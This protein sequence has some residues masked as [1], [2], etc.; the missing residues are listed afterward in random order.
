[1]Y[2]NDVTSDDEENFDHDYIIIEGPVEGED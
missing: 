1:M 2:I